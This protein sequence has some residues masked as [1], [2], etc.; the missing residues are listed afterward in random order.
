MKT[1]K[2]RNSFLRVLAILMALVMVL[3]EP[4]SAFAAE[5]NTDPAFAAEELEFFTE[6]EGEF[7]EDTAPTEEFLEEL[8]ESEES[9]EIELLSEDEQADQ[10]ELLITDE[11]ESDEDAALMEA[12]EIIQSHKTTAVPN[13]GEA[14]VPEENYTV[15]R[16]ADHV[17]VVN[18]TTG[19]EQTSYLYAALVLKEANDQ[20]DFC[21][22][23]TEVAPGASAALSTAY[24]TDGEKVLVDDKS[25][26]VLWLGRCDS[27]IDDETGETVYCDFKILGYTPKFDENY[28]IILVDGVKQYE[29]V[30]M[31]EISLPASSY[32]EYSGEWKDG[33]TEVGMK[34][35][36]QKSLKS[37]KVSWAPSG[38]KNPT[39]KTFKKYELYS[40]KADVTSE[41]GYKA[42]L[43]KSTKEKS[44]TVKNVDINKDS[45]LFLLKCL[46]ST[47]ATVAQYVTCAAPYILKMQSG[48][49]TGNFDFT[50][51]QRPD[52]AEFYIL[53]VAAKN[54]ENDGAK[55][56]TGFQEAWRRIF[57]IEDGFNEGNS[58]GDPYH[59]SKAVTTNAIQLSYDVGEPVVTFGSTYYGRAK[60]VMYVNGLKVTSSP[61]KVLS[62]KAGP[63]KCFILTSA[64]IYYDKTDAKGNNASNKERANE[65]INAFIDGLE[66]S[67][68]SNIFVHN[69]NTDV[70][71]K[72]GLIYF[73]VP[74]DLSNIK[75]FDLMKC[76]YENGKYK[77]LKNYTLSNAAL[78]ECTITNEYLKGYR[79]YAMFYNK[80]T[81]E[82]DAFYAVR[83]V[84]KKS[85]AGGY[86]PGQKIVPSLD[87]VQSLNTSNTDSNKISLTWLS[88]DCVKQ[89]WIYRSE[90]PFNGDERTRAGQNG[91]TRIAK[92]G[93]DKAKK[94]TTT[95]EDTG[96]TR[97]IRYIEY[98]DKK[99]VKVDTPYYYYVRPIYDTAAAAKDN[100]LYMEYCSDEVKGKASAMYAQVKNFKAANE[101]SRKIKISF[102]Q[103]KGLKHYRIFRLKVKGSTKKLNDSMKPD[104]T[105]LYDEAAK[106][107]FNT[108]EEF[109]DYLSGK[110]QDE[111]IDI[112]TKAGVDGNNWEYL[113]TISNKTGESTATKSWIDKN[114]EV[115]RYYFYLI[116]GA[117]DVSSSINFTYTSRVQNVPLP[118][119]QVNAFYSEPGIGLTWK[120]NDKE[121]DISHLTVYISTDNGATWKKANRTGYHDQSVRRGVERT[122]R[123]KVRYYDG[124]NEYYS[125]EVTT[126]YALASGID[127]SATN[128]VSGDSLSISDNV[129]TLKKGETAKISYRAYLENGSTDPFNK[130]TRTSTTNSDI[131]AETGSDG[132]TFTIEA[133]GEG[134]VPYY[135]TCAGLTRKITVKVVK[136]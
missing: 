51:N 120:L 74:E 125:S 73:I 88:D 5:E 81:P 102:T 6:D 132:N 104:L 71:A 136:K 24:N 78:M 18:K 23:G 124:S 43:I 103:K 94:W 116:Q 72:D 52:D 118:V 134:E 117:S 92:I 67:P 28:E 14:V 91:E 50:L 25:D 119:T 19:T 3:G 29:K 128:N 40:L 49:L 111:W 60:T 93:S 115:G 112:I 53:E 62:C 110:P 4:V 105:A 127:V 41:T 114:V 95:D 101:A 26:Y 10:D 113:T 135:I 35:M 12:L 22:L 59:V 68:Q 46:D 80:F 75:S 42:T 79:I 82:K 87:V 89:Y 130:V 54:K 98:I 66:I 34:A 58:I 21:V 33:Y 85:I 90:K 77:K 97:T 129:I 84:G 123:I 38:K 100:T 13:L 86:G 16:Y 107:Q 7:E 99:N 45:L 31:D 17:N 61:S 131:V 126:K 9:E 44:V 2:T 76:N 122:Y 70:C 1:K 133:K 83:A 30:E 32:Q 15:T 96:A 20:G 37:I 69:T 36:V 65:Y 39:H 27:Y 108:L 57:T 56:T 55:V 48:E 109:E 11:I 121:D 106:K 47:G 8:E 63:Q 64:G